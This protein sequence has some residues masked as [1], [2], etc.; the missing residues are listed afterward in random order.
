[1]SKVVFFASLRE[2]TGHSEVQVDIDQGVR[3]PQLMAQLQGLLTPSA[4]E[5]ITAENV[6]IALNHEFVESDALFNPG[7]EIA[8]LPPVT[9][10]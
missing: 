5:A 4:Y 6:R 7:D 10:G 2:A 3:L 9:G 1:V 8:F